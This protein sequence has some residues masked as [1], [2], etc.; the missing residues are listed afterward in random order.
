MKVLLINSNRELA[1]WPIIPTGICR[2]ATALDSAGIE[3]KMLDLTFSEVPQRDVKETIKSFQPGAI[4]LSIRNIDDVD[5]RRMR[6]YIPEIKEQVVAPLK[7]VAP[8]TPFVLGG[9]A[10]GVAPKLLLDFLGAD[11]AVAGDGERA[12]VRVFQALGKGEDPKSIA[13]T[14]APDG[15]G[16][17]IVNPPDRIEELNEFPHSKAY[18]WIDAKRY[19]SYGTR[20]GIQT[21]RGCDRT[22]TYCSYPNLEGRSYRLFDPVSV[23]DEIEDVYKQSGVDRFEFVD[24]TFNIP[25]DHAVGILKELAKRKLPVGLDT[26]GLNPFAVDKELVQAMKDAGFTETSCTPESGS[27]RIIKALGKQFTTEQVAQAAKVLQEANM[28][29][30]WYFMFGAPGENA[31]TIKET[32]AFIDEHIPP[33]DLVIVM[34]GIRVFPGTPLEKACRKEGLVKD[35]NDLF[36]PFWIYGELTCERLQELVAVEVNKRPKCCHASGELWNY[37]WLMKFLHGAFT[38]LGLKS[39]GWNIVRAINTVRKLWRPTEAK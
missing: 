39:T 20:Y 14:I 30:K 8:D 1:P 34:T 2:V 5:T 22:C 23:V 4:G 6:F 21:K 7:E 12:A 18:K 25:R 10:V 31:E 28:P 32:F 26:M 17:L 24:S 36:E 38:T 29:T 3:V 16:G 11:L 35:D 37:P 9:S 15:K 33:T 19:A 27:P 13:G